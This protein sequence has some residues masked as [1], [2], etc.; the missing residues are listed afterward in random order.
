MAP[1]RRWKR[2]CSSAVS[3]I[4]PG[5]GE[6]NWSFRSAE[7]R[8]SETGPAAPVRRNRPASARIAASEGESCTC[9]RKY[10]SR[11]STYPA[12]PASPSAS[13]FSGTP[14]SRSAALSRSNR[15]SSDA[16]FL[17]FVAVADDR[18]ADLR[19]AHRLPRLEQERHQ[20]EQALA[21][22]YQSHGADSMRKTL[23]HSMLLRISAQV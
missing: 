3:R 2:K 15:R 14:S 5:I 17:T 16:R 7:R 22:R 4:W 8:A 23:W 11:G 20:V 6:S 9:G 1:P 10:A 19:K 21:F 12:S 18:L 13:N